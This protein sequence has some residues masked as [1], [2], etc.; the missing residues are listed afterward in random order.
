MSEPVGGEERHLAFTDN[1]SLYVALDDAAIDSVAQL[2]MQQRPSWFNYATRNIIN[3]FATKPSLLCNPIAA[4]PAVK[5]HTNPLISEVPPLPV[6]GTNGKYGI[7]YCLQLNLAKIEFSPGSNAIALPS[8]LQLGPQQLALQV[9]VSGGLAQPTANTIQQ[10]APVGA[11]DIDWGNMDVGQVITPSNTLACFQFDLYLM[12][13]AQLANTPNP[14]MVVGIDG[15]KVSG[16]LAPEL[17]AAVEWYVVNLVV[18]LAI[19]PWLE[20][21]IP[22]RQHFDMPKVSPDV[23]LTLA[24]DASLTP[25]STAVPFNPALVNDQLELYLNVQ[26]AETGQ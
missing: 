25:I 2:A 21:I 26:M 24:G 7:D 4:N 14:P 1:C 16:L 22:T 6:I 8:P 20:K 23:T 13:H 5:A 12:M 19:V 9:E 18:P 3:S 17:E 10:L 11:S 15:L